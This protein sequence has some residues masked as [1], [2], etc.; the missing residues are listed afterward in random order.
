MLIF[1]EFVSLVVVRLSHLWWNWRRTA[2]SSHHSTRRHDNRKMVVLLQI[3]SFASSRSSDLHF[4]FVKESHGCP[5]L[6]LRF[7]KVFA[8]IPC[9][10]VPGEPLPLLCR[11]TNEHIT[12]RWSANA[13]TTSKT[14]F[15]VYEIRCLHCRERRWE[16]N[17]LLPCMFCVLYFYLFYSVVSHF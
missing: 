9:A 17:H 4:L 16:E 5:M 6:T 14:A 12:T 11:Q 8:W 7:Q 1:H 15:T 10:N 13:G 3:V 2:H